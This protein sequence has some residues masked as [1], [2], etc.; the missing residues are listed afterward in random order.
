[1]EPNELEEMSEKT[2]ANG[3]HIIMYKTDLMYI[4]E[5]WKNDWSDCM[6]SKIFKTEKDAKFEYD[7]WS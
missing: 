7:R 1:M 3:G 4:V 5:C 6:W 2:L